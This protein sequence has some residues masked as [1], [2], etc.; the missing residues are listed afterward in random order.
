SGSAGACAMSCAW[1]GPATCSPGSERMKARSPRRL[2]CWSVWWPSIASINCRSSKRTRAGW[3]RC[4]SALDEKPI[5]HDQRHH[6]SLPMDEARRHLREK[7]RSL[8]VAACVAALVIM[9]GVQY[10]STR[11]PGA[12]VRMQPSSQARAY[13]RNIR[14][15]AENSLAQV[16]A[17][18]AAVDRSERRTGEV[19][20]TLDRGIR[21][22]QTWQRQ[23]AALTPP[24][25]FQSQHD[26]VGRLLTE[27][28]S[29]AQ[30]I[31]SAQPIAPSH[32]V[33]HRLTVVHD[34]LAQVLNTVEGI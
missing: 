24:Q 27:L 14:E 9:A 29:M 16:E 19:A 6:M 34:R 30:G 21:R 13:L 1:P 23:F 3:R 8:V 18:L 25:A 11:E 32:P 17:M 2:S 12:G 20:D 26:E 10:L 33:R 22:L 15:L 31:S 7:R 28:R 5:R 4:G